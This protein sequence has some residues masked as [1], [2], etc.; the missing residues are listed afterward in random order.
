MKRN[1][2]NKANNVKINIQFKMK[3]ANRPL[4]REYFTDGS[5]YTCI[6]LKR[7]HVVVAGGMTYIVVFQVLNREFHAV[8]KRK[9]M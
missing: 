2:D 6:I 3:S 4:S 9:G 8:C 7:N 5:P 1:R